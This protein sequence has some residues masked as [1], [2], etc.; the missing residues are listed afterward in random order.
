MN[1]NNGATSA[2][3][4]RFRLAKCT[5]PAGAFALF[6]WLLCALLSLLVGCTAAAAG[7]AP[8]PTPPLAAALDAARR[9]GKPVL[10]LV[11]RPGDIA[12]IDAGH[13]LAEDRALA[14]ARSGFH[15]VTLWARE[16]AAEA[17]NLPGPT[18]AGAWIIAP[19]ELPKSG[20]LFL[21][22]AREVV[23][24]EPV[25]ALRAGMGDLLKR[26]SQDLRPLREV[27]GEALAHPDTIDLCDRAAERLRGAGRPDAALLLL[28]RAP[29]PGD[30]AAVQRRRSLIDLLE[31][32]ARRWAS[33]RL[34]HTERQMEALRRGEPAG[35]A[36]GRSLAQ[37]MQSVRE[38][39]D[40]RPVPAALDAALREADAALAAARPRPDDG[41]LVRQTSE[42]LLPALKACAAD[43]RKAAQEAEHAWA[44]A[45]PEDVK[46]QTWL[47][48]ASLENENEP[49]PTAQGE[50][51]A[52]L[53]ALL[54]RPMS[55]EE[56]LQAAG[57]LAAATVLLG[58]DARRARLAAKLGRE[59]PHGR[60]AA[61]AL[62]DL[63]DEAL[64]QGAA[65]DAERCRRAA[66]RA[67]DGGESP[68]LLRAARASG[69]HSPARALWE[70]RRVLDVVVLAP[71]LGSFA[72]AISCWSQKVFFPVLFQDD[73]YAPRFIAAFRP[74]RV[75]LLPAS[76]GVSAAG[77]GDLPAALAGL[78]AAAGHGPARRSDGFD[79]SDQSGA[80]RPGAGN[81]QSAIAHLQS[82]MRRLGVAPP[83]VVFTDGVCGEVAG[84]LALA[85]GRFQGLEILP[86]PRIGQG[87]DARNAG[88]ADHLSEEA[89]WEMARRIRD[90]M[91][92]WGLTKPDGPAAV[93]L[94]GAYPYRYTG[95]AYGQWGRTYALDDLLG[96]AEDTTRVAVV[97]R[98]LGDSARSAYQAACSLFLQPRSA[99]LFNTYGTGP[100]SIWGFY[101]M[102]FAES[103]WKSRLEVT[104]LR[105]R[106]ASIETFRSHALP[107][108]AGGL[109]VINSSGGAT[110][111]SV[112]GGGG[113]ADD[114]PVGAPTAIHI[115]HSGSAAD[116]YN[117][118]TLAGRAI[119]GGAFWY[120]GSTAEPF[121]SSFQ[122]PRTYAPR[123]AAG[124]PLA[125]VFRQRPGQEF[126][127]PWRLMLI[128]D[129]LFSLREHPAERSPYHGGLQ[130]GGL[131]LQIAG[132]AGPLPTAD[133]RLPTAADGDA[134][135]RW[136]A[137]L[138]QARWR[139]DRAAARALAGNPPAG[140]DVDGAGL[141]M[142]LEEDLLAGDAARARERWSAAP[143]GARRE[144]AARVTARYAIGR[145]MDDAL[146]AKDLPALL[147]AFR[148][149]LS[150]G[151][152]T[153]FV[154][155]W[156][157]K[158]GGLAKEKAATPTFAA[159]LTAQA[160]EPANKAYQPA[161]AAALKKGA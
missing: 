144:Y 62:L 89:A 117:A 137:E 23:A 61:A 1:L 139:G 7:P 82:K 87:A 161:L 101:R 108:N 113:T 120:Y 8:T 69:G 152:A 127:Q 141:A 83:G 57:T 50:A 102:D 55:P 145:V 71:D 22:A 3:P 68:T 18:K 78:R 54:S 9:D 49:K 132:A 110:S 20:F 99:L 80:A 94:A 124:A 135:G 40:G 112:A 86:V 28:R 53:D 29:A 77:A 67:A 4:G 104:H 17:A 21:T 143:A 91:A 142:A 15:C 13:W 34:A 126:W 115:T 32:P 36:A 58:P 121:L 158:A 150:T 160:S 63:A 138:R 26:V 41:Q 131:G 148:D 81:L 66:V 70:R 128:G 140:A 65:E 84:A 157:L 93:T 64:G 151:P 6:R 125:A 60:D 14:R 73:L 149:L 155:R 85:A 79:G 76:T 103:A 95:E 5:F 154:E 136:L 27:V 129:P 51:N 134:A 33:G 123:I 10:V 47:L 45:H 109:V 35:E 46:A 119:W 16:A 74:A 38:S 19:S 97:G 72:A 12:S 75:V 107:W 43:E 100:A 114:F 118:D 30:A 96:R 146:A 90:G 130:I 105:N 11:R 37:G 52:L 56:C 31:A 24:C 59:A 92:R 44:K 98:L 156:L 159:W 133:R 147:A 42:Q 2:L 116:P 25:P 39:L 111:W 122:P 88:P 48:R 153:N 106:D